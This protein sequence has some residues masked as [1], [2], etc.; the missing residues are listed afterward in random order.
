MSVWIQQ[1]Q[2]EEQSGNSL[3]GEDGIPSVPGVEHSPIDWLTHAACLCR[4]ANKQ[5][6]TDVVVGGASHCRLQ[7]HLLVT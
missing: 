7:V 2:A 5:M 4:R 3:T 1:L 6:L